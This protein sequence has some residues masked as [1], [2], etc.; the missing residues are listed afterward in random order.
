MTWQPVAARRS[1]GVPDVMPMT[2]SRDTLL[3]WDGVAMAATVHPVFRV[4][5]IGPLVAGSRA[6]EAAFVLV[7]GG[8]SFEG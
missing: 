7:D 8:T 2:R 5:D 6:P 4:P 1:P 3:R